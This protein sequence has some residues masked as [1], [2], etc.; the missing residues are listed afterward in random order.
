MTIQAAQVDRLTDDHVPP[1]H[2]TWVNQALLLP[3]NKVLDLLRN[4]L[5]RGISLRVNINAQVIERKFTP[6]SS[7]TDYTVQGDWTSSRFDSPL[8]LSGP[9]LGVQVLGCWTLDGG[10]HDVAPVS[11]LASP[12][13]RE[14]LV[15]GGK[16]FR[17]M[18]VPGLSSGVKYRLLLLIWGQ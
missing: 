9:V 7:D 5:N 12:S 16:M 18:Y 8:T 6:P 11:G 10:G 4:L 13:W 15:Q 14:V 17:L 3:I 1:E 2:R